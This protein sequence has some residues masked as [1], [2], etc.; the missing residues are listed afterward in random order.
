MRQV[1]VKLLTD[2]DLI[3]LEKSVNDFLDDM[4]SEFLRDIKFS[5]SEDDHSV[6]YSAMII[7]EFD[8]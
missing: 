7:Y 8:T 3:D 1:G 4:G 5:Q 6:H 2:N